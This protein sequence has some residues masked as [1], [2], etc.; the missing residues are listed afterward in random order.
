MLNNFN[1][2]LQHAYDRIM[3]YQNDV[4]STNA[5]ID[6]ASPFGP[7]A[8]TFARNPD[9]LP[10]SPGANT[11]A[12]LEGL[13]SPLVQ[14]V[15]SKAAESAGVLNKPLAGPSS[16][17]GVSGV[18][19]SPETL[20]YLNAEL[21]SSYGM[22]RTTAYQEALS[23]TSYQRA[24]KDMQAAGLN[25][26]ALFGNG[27]VSGAGGVAYA[28]P[29]SESGSGSGGFR[30]SGKSNNGKLFSEGA[31]AGISTAVGIA[32]AAITGNVGN[33]WLGSTAA[34]GVMTAMNG[35][36]KFFA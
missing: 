6:A 21:A 20:D 1:S 34:K 7:V 28:S 19:L 12:A 36:S 22:D 26:A 10:G 14:G 17:A 27:R 2:T 5:A 8:S 13:G 30:S 16:A 35:A 15:L 4:Q 11:G 9:N 32:T 23:N 18:S 24:V 25:P 29:A 3:H 33:Y 31:Y